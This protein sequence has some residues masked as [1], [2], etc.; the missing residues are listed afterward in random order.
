MK[1]IT[2]MSQKGGVGKSTF[3]FFLQALYKR[4]GYAV[5]FRDEDGQGSI[6]AP[7]ES[8]NPDVVIVD[9]PGHLPDANQLISWIKPSDLIIIPLNPTRLNIEPYMRMRYMLK[10][11][12]EK[13]KQVI[14]IINQYNPSY[15]ASR[16][17]VD[18]YRQNYTNETSTTF[19]FPQSELVRQAAEYQS[20]VTVSSS[21]KNA[22]EM[23]YDTTRDMLGLEV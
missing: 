17:F 5:S 16:H 8:D 1:T 13:G 14:T 3:A 4:D 19:Y 18:W 2:L 21:V 15:I 20:L 6:I 9:T 23:L 10:P 11:W 22:I 12:E 7:Y